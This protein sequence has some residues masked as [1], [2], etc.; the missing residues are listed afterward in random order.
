MSP[1]DPAEVPDALRGRRIAVLVS[2]G[3]S[4]YKVVD[5]IPRLVAAGCEVRVAMTAAA[6]RFI[7]EATFHGLA[8]HP[9]ELP[10]PDEPHAELGEWAEVALVA[11][12]TADLLARLAGGHAGD[13]VSAAVLEAACPV[14]VAPAMNDAMWAKP[15]VAA[16]VATLRERGLTVVEPESG[17]LASGHV[18]AGRLP[19]SAVLLAALAAAAPG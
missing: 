19:G 3:I 12:A 15:A 17:R 18:G 5:L 7:G 1:L 8:G 16:N 11:P 14:V 13:P 6:A 4:A 10:G 9:V 2:G